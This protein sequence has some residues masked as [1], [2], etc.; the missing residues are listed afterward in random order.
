MEDFFKQQKR[1]NMLFDVI[2]V[3]GFAFTLF[4]I[5][6]RLLILAIGL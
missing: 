2:V 4:V 1:L 6:C 5:I 3:L